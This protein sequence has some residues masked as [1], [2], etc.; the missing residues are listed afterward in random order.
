VKKGPDGSPA[1]IQRISRERESKE[2]IDIDKKTLSKPMSIGKFGKSQPESN[3]VS[4]KEDVED[5]EGEEE[6][7]EEVAPE[8]PH[9]D[10]EAQYAEEGEE[11]GEEEEEESAVFDD[12][13]QMHIPK[14]MKRFV[15]YDSERPFDEQG[16]DDEEERQSSK[17][18]A[19]SLNP[20]SVKT[21]K[22]KKEAKEEQKKRIAKNKRKT[23]APEHND[24]I[25]TIDKSD[26]KRLKIRPFPKHLLAKKP[27]DK[28]DGEKSAKLTLKKD[29]SRINTGKEAPK[30]P[31]KE[32]SFFKNFDA[33]KLDFSRYDENRHS[34]TPLELNANETSK[35]L[36][37]EES[38]KSR[39]KKLEFKQKDNLEISP[40]MSSE[41]EEDGESTGKRTET[42]QREI[43]KNEE[44]EYTVP[45]DWGNEGE[46]EVRSV[47]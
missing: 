17:S 34:K 13:S 6:G 2:N 44:R 25:P 43:E 20:K 7:E 30:L 18:L 11:E 14:N 27:E 22:Q 9:Q 41:E 29:D 35:I 10:E 46:V 45:F 36:D 38:V 19:I 47:K 21:S 42:I 15:K 33:S 5:A 8:E 23:V 3:A 40:I 31:P 16:N 12:I 24:S 39:K 4:K 37:K 32:D 1:T 28:K 26:L